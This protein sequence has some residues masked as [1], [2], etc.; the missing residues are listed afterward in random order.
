MQCFEILSRPSGPSGNRLANIVHIVL[1]YF[2]TPKCPPRL[3]LSTKK[4]REVQC[5]RVLLFCTSMLRFFDRYHIFRLSILV[6]ISF[7][8]YFCFIT[9]FRGVVSYFDFSVSFSD[10]QRSLFSS[11]ARASCRNRK[12]GNERSESGT[13]STGDS[14]STVGFGGNTFSNGPSSANQSSG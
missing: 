13:K 2:H 3:I 5:E 8:V 12:F 4:V 9:L 7:C 14:P 6:Y 10:T 11:P 1:A